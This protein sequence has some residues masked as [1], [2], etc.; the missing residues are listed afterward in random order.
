MSPSHFPVPTIDNNTTDD[1][2]ICNKNETHIVP[3]R[4]LKRT[5]TTATCA[6]APRMHEFE[7]RNLSDTSTSPE[8]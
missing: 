6:V 3:N 7:H 8:R 2:D 5:I 4:F 1:N